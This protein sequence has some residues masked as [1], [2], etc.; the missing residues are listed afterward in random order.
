MT[1][2]GSCRQEIGDAPHFTNSWASYHM[3][4]QRCLEAAIARA[5][6][7]EAGVTEAAGEL[8]KLT[9]RYQAAMTRARSA[10]AEAEEAEHTRLWWAH[11][12]DELE[13]ENA[14]LRAERGE[15]TL[16][17]ALRSIGTWGEI[18]RQAIEDGET[19]PPEALTVSFRQ[20][21]AAEMAYGLKVAQEF[22]GEDATPAP[23]NDPEPRP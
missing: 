7:A 2:C 16:D 22:V 11:R 19:I 17:E 12:S 13:A 8:D 1:I 20:L 15:T 3:D 4:G 9:V 5:E 21:T 18:I 23:D 10:E 6:R 14:V